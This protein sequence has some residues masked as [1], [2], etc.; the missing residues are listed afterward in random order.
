MSYIQ[1]VAKPVAMGVRQTPE[2]GRN[3]VGGARTLAD[4]SKILDLREASGLLPTVRTLGARIDRRV[5]LRRRLESEVLVLQ[6]LS[7][8]SNHSGTDFQEFVDKK[9]RYH[10]LGGQIDALA[11]KLAEQ[12]ALVR[13]RDASYVDFICLRHDG[14]AAFCWHRGEERISHWHSLHEQHT[15][16]RPLT[17][18]EL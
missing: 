11:D 7:D 1:G 2:R 3:A 5:A 10:V 4:R 8:A 17:G 13:H 15:R 18:A 14:L 12:G 9:I 6:V 16:R